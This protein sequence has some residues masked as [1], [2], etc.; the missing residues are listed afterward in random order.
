MPKYQKVSIISTNH[1]FEQPR[2][3]DDLAKSVLQQFILQT[4]DPVFALVNTFLF[5]HMTQDFISGSGTGVSRV[6]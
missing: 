3:K 4:E 6:I 2:D 5:G 1:D